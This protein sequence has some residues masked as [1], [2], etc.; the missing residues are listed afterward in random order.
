MAGWNT[1]YRVNWH[2]IPGREYRRSRG[3]Y[4]TCRQQRD[5][6]SVRDLIERSEY[7]HIA[8]HGAQNLEDAPAFHCLFLSNA[9]GAQTAACMR[10]TNFQRCDLRGTELVTLSACE[11]AL[12]RYDLNDNLYGLAA[13]FLRAGART[14]LGALWPVKSDC[15]LFFV[16]LYSEI[17]RDSSKLAAFRHA[18]S[19]TRAAF[20]EYRDWA[21]FILSVTGGRPICPRTMWFK[22]STAAVGYRGCS[23]NTPPRTRRAG[24]R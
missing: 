20:P 14:V 15:G 8:A 17:G 7:V 4:G 18:Q 21:A 12:F 19:V 24:E 22:S 3:R 11:S 1:G 9:D 6:V 10:M 16:V 2:C 23:P 13:A 5:A